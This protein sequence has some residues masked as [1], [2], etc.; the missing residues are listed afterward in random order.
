MPIC[1]SLPATCD[2]PLSFGEAAPEVIHHGHQQY[3]LP[4]E[5]RQLV[6]PLM[7]MCLVLGA[8]QTGYLSILFITVVEDTTL[9]R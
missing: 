3:E 9:F 1:L 5:A 4:L 7:P 2:S 8:L 6:P